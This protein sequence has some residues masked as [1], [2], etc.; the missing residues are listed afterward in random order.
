MIGNNGLSIGKNTPKRSFSLDC[1]DLEEPYVILTNY[2]GE[3]YSY[4]SCVD[5]RNLPTDYSIVEELEAEIWDEKKSIELGFFTAEEAKRIL[6]LMMIFVDT[7]FVNDDWKENFLFAP[8]IVETFYPNYF[9]VCITFRVLT[10]GNV[11]F[12]NCRFSGSSGNTTSLVPKPPF[13]IV[14]SHHIEAIEKIKFLNYP[15]LVKF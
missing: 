7:P 6:S 15:T 9:S 2:D 14:G 11:L 13:S 3:V 12:Y 4:E 1:G 10:S 8:F 5:P